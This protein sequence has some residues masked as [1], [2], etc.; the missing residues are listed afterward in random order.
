VLEASIVHKIVINKARDLAFIKDFNSEL[1]F[2]D[3]ENFRAL[4]GRTLKLKRC[5]QRS[6]I[7]ELKRIGLLKQYNHSLF[8]INSKVLKY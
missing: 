4:I 5:Y 2:I 1:L 7:C 8:S 6:F 3:V